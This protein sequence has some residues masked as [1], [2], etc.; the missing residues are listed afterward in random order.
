V[1]FQDLDI[2]DLF[3]TQLDGIEDPDSD[4]NRLTGMGDYRPGH[5]HTAFLNA[6]PRDPRRPFRR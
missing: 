1:L 2:L 3:D 6:D 5:W 4:R